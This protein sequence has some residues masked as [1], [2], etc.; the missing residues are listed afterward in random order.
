MPGAMEAQPHAHRVI[1]P[2]WALL[3]VAALVGL[4][5]YAGARIGIALT[6][7][8]AP[9]PVLWPP[10][11]LLFAALLLTPRRWW[12]AALAGAL[13]A[14]LIALLH[15]G[16]PLAPVLGGF[17]SNGVEAVLGALLFR[18][19]APSHDLR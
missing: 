8:P 17:A 3:R 1:D 15:A 12:W 5:Y 6:F 13:P 4:G 10:N 2:A 9:V 7:P 14:H 18:H 19:L 11:A 16:A